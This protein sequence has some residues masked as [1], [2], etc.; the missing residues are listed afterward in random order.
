MAQVGDNFFYVK[1][2]S[3]FEVYFEGEASAVSATNETGPFDILKDHA[4]FMTILPAG[5]VKILTRFGKREVEI[6]RGI[7]KVSNNKVI[8]FANV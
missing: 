4:N 2:F 1:I 7:L 6:N 3:P 8:L 5:K